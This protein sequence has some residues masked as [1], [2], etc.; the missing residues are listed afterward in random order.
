MCAMKPSILGRCVYSFL[1]ISICYSWKSVLFWAHWYHFQ[2]ENITYEQCFNEDVTA[3]CSCMHGIQCQYMVFQAPKRI[4]RMWNKFTKSKKEFS[5]CLFELA[6]D[7]FEHHQVRGDNVLALMLSSH[8]GIFFAYSLS[9][10]SEMV[11]RFTLKL[12]QDQDGLTAQRDWLSWSRECINQ[13]SNNYDWYVQI[14]VYR[15]PSAW[16]W[17]LVHLIS[18][19]TLAAGQRLFLFFGAHHLLAIELWAK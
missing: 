11:L 7:T 17:P 2:E 6:P 19:L 16:N 18:F 12:C 10:L 4:K 14:S 5:S 3:I 1:S 8:M 9:W 15:F 13:S